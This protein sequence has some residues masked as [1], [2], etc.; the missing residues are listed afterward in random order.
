MILKSWRI[1]TDYVAPMRWLQVKVYDDVELL[2][3][4]AARYSWQSVAEYAQA[5]GCVQQTPE[6][7]LVDADGKD[8][9]PLWPANGLA[10]VVRLSADHLTTEVIHHE[11]LHAAAVVYRMNVAR[12]IYLGTGEDMENEEKFAYI[13][14]QL[15]AD[16]DTHL[17]KHMDFGNWPAVS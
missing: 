7:W 9:G 15:A 6:R 12:A 8:Q 17:R 10:G 2:R 16:M 3:R 4:A 5:V 1:E 14:G 13:H 11:T